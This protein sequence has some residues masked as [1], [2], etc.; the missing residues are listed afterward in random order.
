M[1]ANFPFSTPLIVEALDASGYVVTDGLDA[2][3]VSTCTNIHATECVCRG[4]CYSSVLLQEV[5][6]E[7]N[8]PD[9]CLSA[10]S[11]F[12]LTQGMGTFMGSICAPNQ[13]NVELRFTVTSAISAT[14]IQSAWSPAFNVTGTVN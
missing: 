7:V 3:L 9:T 11:S 8:P 6:V 12:N 10:D 13:L 1:D 5:T 4:S 14:T 2:N